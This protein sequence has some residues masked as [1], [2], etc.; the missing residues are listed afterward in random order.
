MAKKKLVG[1]VIAPPVVGGVGV[2]AADAPVPAAPSPAPAPRP[3]RLK[4]V[5]G[6]PGVLRDVGRYHQLRWGGGQVTLSKEMA[7]QLPWGNATKLFLVYDPQAGT[8]TL[9]ELN[10]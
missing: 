10:P 3:S 9:S 5:S 1:E 2:P 4:L 7:A 6:K 8:L